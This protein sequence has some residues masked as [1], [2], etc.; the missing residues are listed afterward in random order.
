MLDYFPFVS[1]IIREGQRGACAQDTRDLLCCLFRVNNLRFRAIS[2]AE[3][4][5]QQNNTHCCVHII[6]RA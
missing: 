1:G 4:T 6:C 5:A 3:L 2:R